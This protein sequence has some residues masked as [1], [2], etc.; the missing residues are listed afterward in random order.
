MGSVTVIGARNMA[1]EIRIDIEELNKA[2][3]M[4]FEDAVLHAAI[5]Y[6][7]AGIPVLPLR[8][9][10]KKLPEEG[11]INYLSATTKE[12]TVKKWFGPEGKYRGFNVGIGTGTRNGVMALDIDA[13]PVQGTTGIKE[14]TKILDKEGPL[15]PGPCQKTPSGGFHYLYMWADNAASSSNKVANGIDTRGGTADRCTG[16]I[17]AYPSTIHGKAYCWATGG[18]VPAMPE[19]LST[20]LGQPWRE[21]PKEQAPKQDVPIHQ[22][23]RM[24]TVIDPDGL[25]YEDWV[26]IGMALKSTCGDDGLELWDEWSRHGSRRKNGE[27]TSRWKTFNEDGQ[28]G[29]GTLLFLAKEAGWRP[30]PGDVT[31]GSVNA[32]IEEKV[33][34]FNKEFALVRMGKSVIMATFHDTYGVEF[35]GMQGFYDINMPRKVSVPT[36]KGVSE[37]QLADLWMAHPQRREYRRIGVYPLN[38]QPADTLNM[39][40]GWAVQP[41]RSKS[42]ELW[43]NHIRHVICNGD[44]TIFE[45]VMDWM[46]DAVQ[47]PR[48]LKGTA[49]ILRG[50]EGCGKGAFAD[51]FGSLF[52]KHYNHLIDSERLTGRF[53]SFLNDNIVVY[54]DEVLWPGDRKAANILKGL[55]SER[56]LHIE[57]KGVDTIEV[58]NMNR[59]IIASNET[60]IVPAGPQSRRWLV[61]NVSPAVAKNRPYFTKLFKELE[62]G[63]KEAILAMLMDRKITSDLRLAPTT[64]GL[65]EQRQMSHGH[66]S[67]LH[68]MSE[69]V[70]RGGFQSLDA[71][72]TMGEDVRW[73]RKLLAYEV[74]TEYTAWCRDR[75][76]SNYDRLTMTVFMHNMAGYGFKIDGKKM[77]VPEESALA[78]EVHKRQGVE[79]T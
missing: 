62:N 20:S 78:K 41:D 17:V 52:G 16:H 72:A 71:E 77:A 48:N 60:W 73:P 13:K 36:S 63:G 54:A 53:N 30:L 12:S 15:P 37:R 11:G 22:I 44:H 34:Q 33:L 57:A 55:V 8:K 35:L 23:N 9:N 64:K 6:V 68:F 27:C 40:S 42:C 28:V 61:L 66:D 50:V 4:P 46:A 65:I 3:D 26:K 1:Y 10:E 2:N 32:E 69:V 39:W 19:W 79:D 25:S 31:T 43:L 7:K 56:R 38:D 21:K 75:S 18:E 76:V 24:L 59:V 74:Y 58:D 49:I 45:W 51:T 29:F 67:L 14:L 47:D 70:M 5:C